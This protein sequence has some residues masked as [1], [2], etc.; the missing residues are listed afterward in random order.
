MIE[1]LRGSLSAR[2]SFVALVTAFVA[3]GCS[4]HS[5]GGPSSDA[6]LDTSPSDTANDTANET[7]TDTGDTSEDSGGTSDPI[8]QIAYIKNDQLYVAEADG[9][10]ETQLTDERENISPAWSPDGTELVYVSRSEDAMPSGPGWELW[11]VAA[12]GSNPEKLFSSTEIDSIGDPSWSPDGSRIAFH[13]DHPDADSYD[14][15]TVDADG[16]NLTKLVADASNSVGPT[17]SPD[18]ERLIY[19]SSVSSISEVPASGGES[20]QIANFRDLPGG[21]M[22]FTPSGDRIVFKLGDFMSNIMTIKPD[23]TDQRQITAM[24]G[25]EYGPTVSAD[26]GTIAFYHYPDGETRTTGIWT[27]GVSGGTPELL[28]AEAN[29][30]AFSPE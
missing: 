28:V 5:D 1:R 19:K 7:G 29:Y 25:S 27:V 13:G 22:A 10:E 26:G 17:W 30:P 3:V 20:S 8:G 6:G 23:G 4:T 15:L 24:P 21:R 2:I 16:S 9:S 18:G 14:I 12:D 11:T